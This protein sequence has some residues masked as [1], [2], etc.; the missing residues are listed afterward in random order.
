MWKCLTPFTNKLLYLASCA[1]LLLSISSPATADSLATKWKN[2]IRLQN[3]DAS[4][5]IKLGGRIMND[6]T[7]WL[8]AD[9]TL[10]NE[11]SGVG[12]LEDSA[13]LR[14]ARL[15]VAG[16][17]HNLEFKAQYDWSG[18]DAKIKDMY[19]G[20]T[21]IPVVGKIRVGHQYEAFG[22]EELTSSKYITFLERGLVTAF[23]PGRNSGVRILSSCKD[24]RGTFSIGAYKETDDTA[25]G[26]GDDNFNFTTRLTLA[27]V[28]ED[29]GRKLVHAGAAYSYKNLANDEIRFRARPEIHD[30][31]RFA[32]TET[33][34]ADAAHLVGA[35]LAFVAGSFSAQG[36]YVH[37]F[38]ENDQGADSDFGGFY[39]Y[40]SYFLTGEHRAYKQNVG[41][42]NRVKPNSDYISAD[43]G[44]GAWEIAARISGLDLNDSAVNGGELVD[45]TAGVNWYLHPNAR[46]MLNFIHTDEDT[47]GD[48]QA[49]T[50]R[51]QVDF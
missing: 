33:I 19:V 23:T 39:A 2:G 8:A 22:L 12:K 28:Y 4:I 34:A 44:S 21:N 36:E 31:P 37:A 32:D 13:E 50:T 17:I 27:P 16:A 47:L 24:G 6:Y 35:E 20:I 10:E 11:E 46:V 51:F 29:E 45:F 43:P 48:A 38:T 30:S 9:K 42:F 49:I 18:G 7:F 41:K 25:D 14:R 3:E 26:V 1:I 15:Y 5:K 40:V